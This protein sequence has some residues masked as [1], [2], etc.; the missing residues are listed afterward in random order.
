MSDTAYARAEAAFAAGHDATVLAEL[1]EV[2]AAPTRA[3]LPALAL[4]ANAAIRSGAWDTAAALLEAL[5]A[6]RPDLPQLRLRLATAH[7]NAG[8]ARLARGDRA[9]ARAGFEA[10]LALAPGHA[11]ALHNRL[12]LARLDSEIGAFL[13]LAERLHA[14]RPA[15]PEAA[16]LHAEAALAAGAPETA[17]GLVRQLPDAPPLAARSALVLADLG[18]AGAA[19]AGIDALDATEL[20]ALADRLRGNGFADA[21]RTA[22]AHAAR[23]LGDGALVPGLR[24]RIAS[25]LALPFVV[26]D[27]QS[28]QAARAQWVDGLATLESEL[29][30]D[31]LSACTPAL[32]QL[33]WSN[34]LLAYQGEDDRPLQQRYAALLRRGLAALAPAW[35]EPPRVPARARP[36]VVLVSS[37]F[38]ECTVGA[39]F[40]SWIG[41][42]VDAGWETLV[43]QL[44]PRQDRTTERLLARASSGR[45]LDGPL[46]A[47]AAA[48]R[49][50]AA[51][52]AIL[53]EIGMDM[54]L[55]ALACV[56]LAPRMLA[57]WG[58]PVTSGFAHFAGYLTAGPMEPADADAHYVEPLLRLPGI[59]TA[60]T[61]PPVPQRRAR[62]ALGLP[63][64]RIYLVPQSAFKLHPEDDA[65]IA[66]LA[67]RDRGARI[68]LVPADRPHAQRRHAERLAAALRAAGAD[69][70]QLHF[71]P[72]S[73]RGRFLEFC[74]AADVMFDTRRWSGGN[75]TLDAL[76]A[77]LPVVACPGPWMRSRQSAAM[78]TLMGLDAAL[79]CADR[80]AQV[81]RAIA[82]AGDPAERA[83][84]SA[85]IEAAFPGL[86][87]GREALASLVQHLDALRARPSLDA[88]D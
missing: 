82:I 28:L 69:P 84:L 59:G 67:A 70:A 39:Y 88:R 85:A 61:A 81:E 30:T 49:E 65:A 27:A 83:R 79:V 33:A 24:H 63:P 56:A 8:R 41:A 15:D 47:I 66:E 34:F 80:R 62:A 86:V 4:A 74:A 32:E 20:A 12:E 51:D 36:R 78:L 38:R 43:V 1:A 22:F 10:A 73:D 35:L 87:D 21:A 29:D 68:A 9:G 50:Q 53:P 44:G 48:I 14:A 2:V 19:L 7:N 75:T 5:Y 17:S 6:R 77:G 40:G 37:G 13:D 58:H 16:L 45:V 57:A 76:R 64:G 25:R 71:L 31:A 60:Y 54:R 42:L 46:D 3:A 18:E 26:D 23:R 11:E 72:L 55:Q 52:V